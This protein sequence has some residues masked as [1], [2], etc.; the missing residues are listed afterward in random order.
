[1]GSLRKTAAKLDQ[2]Q[3]DGPTVLDKLSIEEN[4]RSLRAAPNQTSGLSS[5]SS[6]PY[7][8]MKSI[9]NLKQQELPARSPYDESALRQKEDEQDLKSKP[10]AYQTDELNSGTK[11]T[12]STNLKKPKAT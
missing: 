1:L 9:Y 12:E 11:A 10:F 8:K 5:L 4:R 2:P 6:K 7:S 3:T